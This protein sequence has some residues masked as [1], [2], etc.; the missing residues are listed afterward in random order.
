MDL[1]QIMRIEGFQTILHSLVDVID[2]GI[3][4]IDRNGLTVI[5][6]KKM[7]EIEGMDSK[8]VL[9]EKIH[10]IFKFKEETESTLVR[11]LHSGHATEN[12][13]QTYFNSLGQEISTINNTYPIFDTRQN[14]IGAIEVA[15]DITNL[16]R[17]IKD[18]ILNKGDTKYT[19]DS[20]LG[21]SANF[22]EVIEKSKRS[23]RTYS[24]ILIVGETGTGK[25][26][27]AQ[28]IH[29]G[30]SRSKHPFISQNCAALPDS[31]IEGILFGTKKGAFTGSVERPG[32]FEQA[33]G[34]T[35]LLDEINSLNPN[36]QA[37]LLRALQER[38]I[39][40]V[41]DTKDKNIDVRVIATINE[42]PIDAIS[43]GHLRKDLYYRL[44]VVS[45]FIP[46][47]RE[48]KEDIPLLAQSFIDKFNALFELDI[49]GISEEAYE[50]FYDYEWHGNVRELEHIIEGAMNLLEPGDKHIKISHLPTLF[51]KKANREEEE[52]ETKAPS[53]PSH[54][55]T[56][57][58]D[59]YMAHTEKFYLEKVLKE[60]NQ[61]ISQAAKALNI[62]RQSLQYRLKKYQAKN[63]LT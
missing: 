48:R 10:D 47:L 37:K 23:T 45:L 18:N 13:K 9:G 30:S 21:V 55:G 28:S 11:A 40:R 44:S 42:D 36:L 31:L 2:I 20:I 53:P 25:E 22:L 51:K 43:N 54:Q 3:H 19:F 39:R 34:G 16:E 57:P 38:K 27:F 7:A 61:N 15:K 33:E 32:L 63:P 14:I 46:P 6:N 52:M 59:D 4:I 41:G 26:L 50:L 5:Y 8:D 29:N 24:T 60:H 17:I 49:E 12:S 1:N 62:S 56:L 58:L 35:I